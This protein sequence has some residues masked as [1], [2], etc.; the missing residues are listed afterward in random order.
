MTSL[1]VSSQDLADRLGL[2]A[3]ELR[4]Q[5]ADV[6]DTLESVV[7]IATE[8]VPACDE[9]GV[10][11]V[12]RKG[13]VTTPAATGEVARAGDALQV[14]LNEGPC[15]DA[16][17]SQEVVTSSNLAADPRWP[18]WGPRI[19]HDF[20][21]GSMLCVRLFTDE[22]TLGALNLYSLREDAFDEAAR[23]EALALAA[24]VAVALAAAQEIGQLRVAIESR[25]VIGQAE[26]ILMERFGLSARQAFSTLVGVSSV[27]NRKL[28]TIA[29]ELVASRQLPTVPPKEAA[30][31]TRP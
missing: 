29:T 8:L 20:A 18:Q 15:L 17:W 16:L 12:R 19:A 31:G 26:G 30:T 21:V 9:A 13:G 14:E 23:I 2:I 10:T 7:T 22:N 4:T 25:T 11:L 1:E 27:T 3:R 6:T 28:S 24:H 5:S